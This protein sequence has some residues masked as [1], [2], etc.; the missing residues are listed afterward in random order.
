MGCGRSVG[1]VPARRGD[2][3]PYPNYAWLREHAPVSPLV[4]PNTNRPTWFVTSYELAK[5]CLGDDRLSL[6]DRNGGDHEVA[7]DGDEYIG[8]GLLRIDRPEHTRLRRLVSAVFSP[9]AAERARPMVERVCHAAIDRFIDRGEADVI[10]EYGL[11]VPVA[12]IHELLGVPEEERDDPAHCLDL[13]VR[14]GLEKPIE[15]EAYV[16]LVDYVDRLVRYKRDHPGDDVTTLLLG[17]LDSGKLRDVRELRSMM[18]SILGAGHISTVQFLGSAILR[19]LQHTDQLAMLTSGATRW[20]DAVHEMLRFDPPVQ[21]SV[22]RYATTDL[23]IGGVA[24]AKGDAVLISLGSANRDGD[25]FDHADEFHSGH[26]VRPNLAFGYGAHLCLGIHLARVEGEVALD[27]LFR[28]LRD[29]RPAMPL[30]EVTWG[31]GPMLRGPLSVRIAFR[32]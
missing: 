3:D 24:V 13:F 32:T 27:V 21:A 14:G 6:D 31:Y 11:P 9:G 20:K 1:Q 15:H 4:T 19:L 25:T 18:L 10:T 2:P 30:E 5:A 7:D 26:R 12:V 16:E 28:R 22:Y 8:R 17:Q 23:E 29:V